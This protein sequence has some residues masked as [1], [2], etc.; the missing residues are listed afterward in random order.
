MDDLVRYASVEPVEAGDDVRHVQERPPVLHHLRHKLLQR[1]ENVVDLVEDVI[2]EELEHVPV[3]SLRP[4]LVQ[5]QLSSVNLWFFFIRSQKVMLGFPT[6][7]NLLW[8]MEKVQK[9]RT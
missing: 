7:Y 5:V 9:S 8:T 3:P 6:F 4:G 1:Q 2:P